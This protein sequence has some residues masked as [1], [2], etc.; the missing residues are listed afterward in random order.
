MLQPGEISV[1]KADAQL[2]LVPEDVVVVDP[3]GKAIK[4]AG[5]FYVTVETIDPYHAVVDIQ[6]R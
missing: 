2:A 3:D 4:A 5:K 1:L 6:R